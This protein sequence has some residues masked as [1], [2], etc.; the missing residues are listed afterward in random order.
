MDCMD[1]YRYIIIINIFV[2]DKHNTSHILVN[3]F[4]RYKL[5]MKWHL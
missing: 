5:K 1:V 2:R 4:Y 3:I